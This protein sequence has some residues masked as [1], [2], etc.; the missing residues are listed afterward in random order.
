M[1]S[2]VGPASRAGSR[3]REPSGTQFGP[4]NPRRLSTRLLGLLA[5]NGRGSQPTS[6]LAWEPENLSIPMC[7]VPFLFSFRR[8]P[9]VSGGVIGRLTPGPE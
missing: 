2:G 3:S 8:R 4:R 7:L 5:T 9:C 6:L 1:G